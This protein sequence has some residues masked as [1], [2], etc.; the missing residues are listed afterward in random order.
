MFAQSHCALS[1][2]TS[3]DRTW[4][5]LKTQVSGYPMQLLLLLLSHFSRI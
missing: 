1:P 2:S 4:Q 3:P 5:G